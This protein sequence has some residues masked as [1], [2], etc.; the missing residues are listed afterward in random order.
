M[1][2]VVAALAFPRAAKWVG[3]GIGIA[4]SLMSLLFVGVLVHERRSSGQLEFRLL[5]RRVAV[6]S[7]LAGAMASVA[8]WQIVGAAVFKPAI[9]R[10]L[11]LADGLAIA[12]LACAGLVAH[13]ITRERVV[14]ILEVV[15]RPPGNMMR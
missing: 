14:H 4:G 3:L 2:L 9:A 7:L 15:E 6:S 10:W 11:T 12:V 5:G 8:T 1:L 13:E